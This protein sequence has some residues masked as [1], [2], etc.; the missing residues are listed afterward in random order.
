MKDNIDFWYSKLQENIKWMSDKIKRQNKGILEWIRNGVLETLSE[1]SDEREIMECRK[2][3][4]WYDGLQVEKNEYSDRHKELL[5]HLNNWKTNQKEYQLTLNPSSWDKI[6][7]MGADSQDI[8]VIA[9]TLS[10]IYNKSHWDIVNFLSEASKI[11][12]SDWKFYIIDYIRDIPEIVKVLEKT[13]LKK[14]YKVNKWS[15]VCCFDKEWLSE[16]L[17]KEF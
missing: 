15:F 1:S 8:V 4:D 10:H 13:K 3:I 17:E 11:L 7:W 16:F 6:E 12:K 2:K 14:Y 9:H 5:N